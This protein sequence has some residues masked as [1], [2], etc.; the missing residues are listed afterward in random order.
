MLQ[1]INRGCFPESHCLLSPLQ[2][3]DLLSGSPHPGYVSCGSHSAPQHAGRGGWEVVCTCACTC[4][5]FCVYVCVCVCVCLHACVCGVVASVYIYIVG[6]VCTVI[7]RFPVPIAHCNHHMRTMWEWE[8]H[9]DLVAYTQHLRLH[10]S[11]TV[12]TLFLAV[13]NNQSRLET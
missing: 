11:N 13:C 2:C 4:S 6:V 1:C 3:A 8:R 9:V 12:I 7:A 5:S 10:Q